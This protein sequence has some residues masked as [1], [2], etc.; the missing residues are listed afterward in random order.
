VESVLSF[1]R[2]GI[3]ARGTKPEN[4]VPEAHVTPKLIDFGYSCE[5]RV[6]SRHDTVLRRHK[7]DD[8]VTFLQLTLRFLLHVGD[9]VD[10]ALP[11]RPPPVYSRLPEYVLASSYLS[12]L[13]TA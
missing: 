9:I 1:H 2:N 10:D 5:K 13:S 3:Q 11:D 6:G 4:I 7:L 12:F 8:F